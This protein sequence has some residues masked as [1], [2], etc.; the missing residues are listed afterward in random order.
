MG[1]IM[2]VSRK[3]K[4]PISVDGREY[5]W[6]IVVDYEPPF[7]PSAGTSL[8]VVDLPG[9]LFVEYHLGQPPEVCHVVVQGRRFRSVSGCGGPHRRFRCPVFAAGPAVSPADVAALIRWCEK[10]GEPVEVNYVGL[11]L[12][13]TA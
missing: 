6:W 9:E 8:K 3:R 10:A 1:A 4:R 2:A 12:S 13:P 11:S 5:L 7:V